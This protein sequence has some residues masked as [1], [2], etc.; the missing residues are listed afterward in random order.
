[1]VE[2]RYVEDEAELLTQLGE[3]EREGRGISAA[4][5]RDDERTW[6]EDAVTACV[7][8][9]GADDRAWR[10]RG[11]QWLGSDL[12]RRPRAYESLA[13]PTELPSRE[14]QFYLRRLTR[15]YGD[16]L[17]LSSAARRARNSSS[18]IWCLRALQR[19][20]AGRMLSIALLP[21]RESGMR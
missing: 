2:V 4:G 13:L 17:L 15:I 1:M 12:N 9:D 8:A 10:G 7:R 18:V 16:C 19:P 6:S 20:H 11:H 5:D 21:P 3:D 14:S